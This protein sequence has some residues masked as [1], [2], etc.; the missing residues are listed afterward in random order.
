MYVEINNNFE[1]KFVNIILLINFD[2]CFGGR[3]VQASRV[4]VYI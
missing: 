3:F 4:I 2:I 1:R